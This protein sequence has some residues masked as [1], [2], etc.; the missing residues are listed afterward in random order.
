MTVDKKRIEYY[1]EGK[2]A[3]AY[4]GPICNT[5]KHR[6]PKTVKCA[7]YPAGI[8]NNILT[9]KVDHRK[10]YIKDNGIQYEPIE[11]TDG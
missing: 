9:S 2:Q 11:A 8:P 5:C 7:A 3:D 10:P 4:K 6:K 1:S